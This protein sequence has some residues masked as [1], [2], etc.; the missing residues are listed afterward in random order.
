MANFVVPIHVYTVVNADSSL[1]ELRQEWGAKTG[2]GKGV[3]SII[4]PPLVLPI[5]I[6]ML[7]ERSSTFQCHRPLQ[8]PSPI[9][10][11]QATVTGYLRLIDSIRW[12]K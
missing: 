12:C 3:A 10:D 5:C 8:L 1:S 6:E 7:S 11:G 4:P 2:P 9:V